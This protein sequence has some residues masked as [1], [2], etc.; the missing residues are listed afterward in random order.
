MD[1]SGNFEGPRLFRKFFLSYAT[2]ILVPCAIGLAL[3]AAAVGSISRGARDSTRA[4]LEQTMDIVDTRVAELGSTARQLSLNAD[5]HS[6]LGKKAPEEGDPAYYDYWTLWKS[7]PN[8]ALTNSFISSACLVSRKSGLIVSP[9]QI[10]RK[11][12]AGYRRE[13][14]YSAWGAEEWNDYLFS[15]PRFNE[16]LPCESLAAPEAGPRGAYFVQS[17]LSSGAFRPEGA[18]VAF[19]DEASIRALRRIDTGDRGLVLVSDSAG[20]IVARSAGSSSTLSAARVA[21]M[22][23]EG[24]LGELERSGYIVSR[25]SSSLTGWDFVSALPSKVVLAPARRIRDIALA[26]LAAGLLLGLGLAAA[27]ATRSSKPIT[28]LATRFSELASK[29][30]LV[31][32]E[33]ELQAPVMRA[34]LARRL[35]LGLYGSEAEASALALAS[36]SEFEG[37]DLVPVSARI[38][39]YPDSGSPELQGELRV[40]RAAL[41]EGLR[42]DPSLSCLAYEPDSV[43][44]ASLFL[45]PR[46]EGGEAGVD[47]LLQGISARLLEDFR[48]RL[49]WSRG[50]AV[51]RLQDLPASFA[52]ASRLLERRASSDPA[53]ACGEADAGEEPFFFPVESELRLVA[54]L[55]RSDAD[56]LRAIME[57]VARENLDERSLSDDAFGDLAAA[58]RLALQR[59][60]RSSGQAAR[61]LA[62]ADA[63]DRRAWFSRAE[64]ILCGLCEGV[65]RTRASEREDLARAIVRRIGELYADPSLTIYA[66]AREFGL[67]ESSFYHF[68]RDNLGASF[69][70]Y[71]ESVRIREARELLRSSPAHIKDIAA[72]VGFASDTTF[73]RAFRRVVGVSPSEYLRAAS[74]EHAMA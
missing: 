10:T 34:D 69:A 64:E 66:A 71:L 72:A 70:D 40:L 19:I 46:G 74:A 13:F 47:A 61:A 41:T 21:A 8:Y 62:E 45:A 44:V 28:E 14:R 3:Y 4:I 43:S 68:F 39:G 17:L 2:V 31:R 15:K 65:A 30:E 54:A 35:L 18:F 50:E 11:D 9:E 5:V 55:N 12:S 26:V 33:L 67:S 49:A 53:T 16:L 32:R 1:P 63:E 37:R 56:A 59:G 51:A 58:L 42:G 52:R 27:M 60:P 20:R 7:L 29:D 73:R 6:L 24:G 23:A 22:A 38:E 57:E 25:A 36:R 48:I